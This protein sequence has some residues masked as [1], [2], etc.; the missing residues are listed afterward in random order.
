MTEPEFTAETRSVLA[1]EARAL[2]HLVQEYRPNSILE[3]G[4]HAGVSTRA[5]ALACVPPAVIHTVD[6]T[7]AETADYADRLKARLD[8]VPADVYVKQYVTTSD[9]FFQNWSGGNEFD[10]V[11]I[12]G[13]HEE[14]SVYRDISNAVTHLRHPNGVIILHDVFRD[15]KPR[16]RKA[17]PGP[18][19]AATRYCK[20]HGLDLQPLGRLPWTTVH[21]LNVTSLAAITVDGSPIRYAGQS[22]A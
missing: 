19:K 15:H 9:Q 22:H 18:R 2:Y 16:R 12:D 5:M 17:I 3:I 7:P 11:F 21:G 13:D 4:R 10:F 14:D 6:P 8:D 20:E 1:C